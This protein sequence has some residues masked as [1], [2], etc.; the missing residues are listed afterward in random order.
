MTSPFMAAQALDMSSLRA[1]ARTLAFVYGGDHNE[2]AAVDQ[3]YAV[4]EHYRQ[5]CA[6]RGLGARCPLCAIDRD[7][8]HKA[9]AELAGARTQAETDLHRIRELED[10]VRRLNQRIERLNR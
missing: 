6:D 10:T 1:A 7:T 3:A 5:A 2:V 8:H 4:L 9:L